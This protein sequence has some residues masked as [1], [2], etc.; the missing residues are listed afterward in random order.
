M[1]CVEYTLEWRKDDP[2]CSCKNMLKKGEELIHAWDIA[3]DMD[4]KSEKY[5]QY[6]EYCNREGISDTK[7]DLNKMLVVD[8]IIGNVDR[9]FN[10]FGYI[11]DSKTLEYKGFAPI[12]DC[13]DSFWH[14]EDINSIK[15]DV[16]TKSK[17]FKGKHIDQIKKVSDF[18]WFSLENMHDFCDDMRTVLTS[19]KELQEDRI[20]SIIHTTLKRVNDINDRRLLKI[21]KKKNTVSRGI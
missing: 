2:R 19:N 7:G 15:N 5:G 3:H 4:Q 18:S 16:N 10:N 17:P 6:I 8:Y 1:P 11:R 13:G 21:N 12:Y 20:D 9:H 14:N